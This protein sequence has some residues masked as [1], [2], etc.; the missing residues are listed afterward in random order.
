M[1]TKEQMLIWKNA[2]SRSVVYKGERMKF[3]QYLR[4]VA[5][6]CN[7]D[8]VLLVDHYENLKSCYCAAGKT[9]IKAYLDTIYG[10]NHKLTLRQWFKE[11]WQIFKK[12]LNV[13]SWK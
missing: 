5:N 13:F 11:K 12:K 1:I 2:K 9:G 3:R 7:K 6:Q 10:V 4:L 8:S